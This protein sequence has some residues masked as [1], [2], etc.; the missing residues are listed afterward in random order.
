MASV[1]LFIFEFGK[2]I[3]KCVA[4]AAVELLSFLSFLARGDIGHLRRL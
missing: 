3:A 1:V 4:G 2:G